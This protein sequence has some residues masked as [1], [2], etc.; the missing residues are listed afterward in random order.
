MLGR[1]LVALLRQR[2]EAVIAS[3]RADLDVTDG[4][5]VGTAMRR[6]RPDYVVNCAAWTAVD[7]A[8]EHPGQALAVNGQGAENVAAACAATGA[9]L[10]HL[11][12]DYVFGGDATRPYPE[13]H[14]PDPGTAYGRG[15][16]AG[17]NAVLGLLPRSG[18]VLRTAWLYGAHGASFAATMIERAARP[19]PVEVVDD[20]WGQPTWTVDVARQIAALAGAGARPGIYHATSA[21]ETTWCRFAREIFRLLGADP[22]R[23]RA[24]GS[25]RF[26]RPA[27]RPRYSVLGHDG[28]ARAGVPPI[29]GWQP[30]LAEAL[31]RLT[32]RAP[33]AALD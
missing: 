26:P 16:L 4:R 30:A 33:A 22:G 5:E 3:T 23:V 2:E 11:S 7:A 25:D 12:T 8:E 28:W 31:P 24:V 32:E 18:V 21:G 27:R 10:L 6:H 29:R 1:D 20:Q 9:R 13:E 17:E 19:G 14:P 15:K